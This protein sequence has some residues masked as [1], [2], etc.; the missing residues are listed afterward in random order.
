MSQISK[1]YIQFLKIII[2]QYLINFIY[3]ISILC[4]HEILKSFK[5]ILC[6]FILE[7]C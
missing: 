2:F 3:K 1:N 4:H 5:K 7:N 6:H